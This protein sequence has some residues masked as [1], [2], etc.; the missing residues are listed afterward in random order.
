MLKQEAVMVDELMNNQYYATI[1][2]KMGSS[3]DRFA[4][5]KKIAF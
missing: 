3:K 4:K 2:M 5:K 1:D